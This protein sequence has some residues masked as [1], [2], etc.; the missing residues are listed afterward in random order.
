M[1]RLV[2]SMRKILT[3]I[4]LLPVVM[5][6]LCENNYFPVGTTW[7]ELQGWWLID[8]VTYEVKDEVLL[9]GI[10]Y[11]EIF[12]DGERCC[13]IREE[14]PL[15]YIWIDEHKNGLLYDFDW[16]EGKDYFACSWEYEPFHETIFNIEEK[17]LND[18]KSYRIWSPEVMCGDYIICGIGGTNSILNYY[19]P[20]VTGGGNCLLEFTR[21]VNVFDNDSNTDNLICVKDKLPIGKRGIRLLKNATGGYDLQIRYSDGSWHNVK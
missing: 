19:Y 2:Y 3:L 16:Y 17:S 4:T 6:A 7:K 21:D 14:G 9:D 15:V 8:T 10:P 13:L 12:K 20:A 11:N 1:K 5:P 18:N